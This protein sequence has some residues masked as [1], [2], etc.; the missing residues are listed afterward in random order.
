MR[1]FD[2]A[3]ALAL[4]SRL[5]APIDHAQVARRGARAAWAYPVIGLLLGALSGAVLLALCRAGVAPAVAAALA[6]GVSILL[7]GAL[8]EDG[9]A[10]CADGLGGAAER[11]R[12]L[13]IMRDSRVGAFGA[14][15][16][17][18]SL[19]TRWSALSFLADQAPALGLAA[20]A[21][22]GAVSRSAMSGALT[23]SPSARAEGLAASQGKAPVWS[24]G[25][26]V[27]L[28]ALAAAALCG[29]GASFGALPFHVVGWGWL[30]ALA[31]AGAFYFYAF[32]RLGGH[33]GDVLGGGQQI[34]EGVF[35]AALTAAATASQLP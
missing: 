29:P 10:D 24:G 22:A 31:A 3:A 14:S 2:L 35:L 12:A 18:I 21:S 23:L 26:A 5:P 20:M 17:L 7:T 30:L 25:L 13:E 28:G 1:V 11:D 15:A 34:A 8:H 6:L 9:L 19:L 16:L 33:T 32:R 4:L 27:L